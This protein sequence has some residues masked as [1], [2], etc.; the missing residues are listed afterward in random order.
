MTGRV[1]AGELGIMYV[2]FDEATDAG[3]GTG[4]EDVVLEGAGAIELIGV[5]PRFEEVVVDV[6]GPP[7]MEV[8]SGAWLGVDGCAILKGVWVG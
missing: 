7:K 2:L 4:L 6:L 3:V 1:F 5:G 8:A